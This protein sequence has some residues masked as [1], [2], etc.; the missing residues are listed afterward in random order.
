MPWGNG[1]GSLNMWHWCAEMGAPLAG[2]HQ[3]EVL[4]KVG[5]GNGRGERMSGKMESPRKGNG[6]HD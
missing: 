5:L 6:E 1:R 3:E 4:G 2:T